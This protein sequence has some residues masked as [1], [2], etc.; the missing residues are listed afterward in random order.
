MVVDAETLGVGVDKAA[1]FDVVAS[2]GA[3]WE[4]VLETNPA[5]SFVPVRFEIMVSP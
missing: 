1:L 3:V 5:T 4:G 2:D